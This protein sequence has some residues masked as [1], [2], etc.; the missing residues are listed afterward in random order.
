[1]DRDQI[2]AEDRERVDRL[3]TLLVTGELLVTRQGWSLTAAE[4]SEAA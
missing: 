1:V 2:A 4:P 3:A